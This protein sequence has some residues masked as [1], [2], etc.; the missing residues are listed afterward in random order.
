[1]CHILLFSGVFSKTFPGFAQG[2]FE[3]TFLINQKNAPSVPI[4][5]RGVMI[6]YQ[7]PTNIIYD[8]FHLPLRLWKKVFEGVM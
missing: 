2:H 4:Q 1:V 6:D 7:L 5:Y 8:L 3:E